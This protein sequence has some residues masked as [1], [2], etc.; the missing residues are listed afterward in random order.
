VDGGFRTFN[1]SS[2][3]AKANEPLELELACST[4]SGSRPAGLCS[5]ALKQK[6]QEGEI[7]TSTSQVTMKNKEYSRVAGT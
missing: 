3:E 6:S 1:P 7:V 5:E 2:W 4:V